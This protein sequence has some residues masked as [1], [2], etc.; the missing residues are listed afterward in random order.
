VSG[1]SMFFPLTIVLTMTSREVPGTS[2]AWVSG[3]PGAARGAAD[4]GPSLHPGRASV[5]CDRRSAG[6]RE[7]SLA[8]A[9]AATLAGRR[10]V[11]IVG[12]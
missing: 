7:R 5:S 8:T 1:T 2:L 10:W 9:I 3:C 11:A 6:D 4:R 12:G